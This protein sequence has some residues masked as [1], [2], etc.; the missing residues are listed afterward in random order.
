MKLR[1]SLFL[2]SVHAAIFM[3]RSWAQL[4]RNY[5]ASLSYAPFSCALSS[6]RLP[7]PLSQ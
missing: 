2:K 7:A 3:A 1:S 4:K 5:S 6:A